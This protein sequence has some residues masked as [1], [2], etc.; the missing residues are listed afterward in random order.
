VLAGAITALCAPAL[1]QDD[2][3]EAELE[4]IIT[5]GTRITNQNVIAAS[6]VTSIGLEEIE[7]KQTPN[8]ERTLSAFSAICPSRSRAT[9]RTRTTAR[10]AR[11]RSTCGAWA[12]N[13]CWS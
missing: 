6:P 13:A 5:T 2:A 3:D 7:Q 4:E 11:R 1:A 12:K 8:I 9:A 10:P